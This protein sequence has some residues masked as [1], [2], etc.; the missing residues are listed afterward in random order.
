MPLNRH[1][2]DCFSACLQ[3]LDRQGVVDRDRSRT[4][5]Q[6]QSGY[7]DASSATTSGTANAANT[8]DAPD[9]ADAPHSSD[10]SNKRH[11]P[12]LLMLLRMPSVLWQPAFPA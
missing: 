3:P 10:A 11:F 9:T 4:E 6:T 2:A 1:M 8:A 12:L 7:A 5:K